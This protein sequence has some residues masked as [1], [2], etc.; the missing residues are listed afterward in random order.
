V[1]AHPVTLNAVK[2][3]PALAKMT[4]LRISRLSVQ[5]VSEDEFEHILK[6]GK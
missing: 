4:L 5:P 3:E 1:L 6:M 2:A